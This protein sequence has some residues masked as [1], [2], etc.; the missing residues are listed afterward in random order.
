MTANFI[1]GPGLTLEASV[2]KADFGRTPEGAAVDVFTLKSGQVE[3]RVLPYGA[4]L[5]SVTAPDSNGKAADVVLGYD[6]LSQWLADQKTHFGAIVG[7]YGNRIAK[8]TFMIDGHRDQ[9]PE[10]NNGNALHGGTVGFD[11][12]FWTG[13]A[14][15]DGVELTLVSPDGDMGFPGTLTAKVTYVLTQ[16]KLTIHYQQTSDKATVVNL[17]NHAYFNL[18]GDDA[19]DVLGHEVTL[20]A[21]SFTPIDKTLTPT[22]EISRVEGTPLDFRGPHT[23]GERIMSSD[24]QIRLAGGYDH[25]WIL[26][27]QEGIMRQAAVVR[28]PAT[29]RTLTVTTTE[30]GI[31]FYSGNFLDGT[32]TGRHG[33]RYMKHMGFCLE[34]QHFPDS[35]NHANFPSTLLLPGQVRQSATAFLFGVT[36]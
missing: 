22:G 8:G 20:D 19:T 2:T 3:A 32:F 7:R 1:A 10:N 6:T 14:I 26:D 18:S 4:K 24:E 28:D 15:R 25:N 16:N 11:R 13:R 23:I 21:Q 27:G 5:I 17:T 36:P 9:I 34:T 31:Q 33:K 12:K 29:G 35:P 30:P